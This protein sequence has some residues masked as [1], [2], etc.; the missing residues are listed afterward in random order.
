MPTPFTKMVNMVNIIPANIR[1]E[2]SIQHHVPHRA[3]NM[4]A[5]SSSFPPIALQITPILFKMLQDHT[6]ITMCLISCLILSV[7][8]LE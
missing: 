6:C 8:F 4:A 2:F 7:L 1:S 5:D 3:A